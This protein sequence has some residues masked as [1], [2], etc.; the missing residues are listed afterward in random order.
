MAYPASPI[1][2]GFDV[3][4]LNSLARATSKTFERLA[5]YSLLQNT[6]SH[7]ARPAVIKIVNKVKAYIEA[8]DTSIQVVH[9]VYRMS[10]VAAALWSTP[11]P[12]SDKQGL[13]ERQQRL[14]DIV[15]LADEAH[16][17]AQKTNGVFKQV[18]QDFYRIAASTKSLDSTIQIPADPALPKLLKK[19]LKDIGPDL[20]SNLSLLSHFT[21]HSSDLATWCSWIKSSIIAIDGTV[22]PPQNGSLF[23][24]DNVRSRWERVRADCLIY[25]SMISDI[26][27]RYS[28]MLPISTNMWQATVSDLNTAHARWTENTGGKVKRGPGLSRKVSTLVQDAVRHLSCHMQGSLAG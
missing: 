20:V 8:I 3:L 28:A 23:E 6:S 13:R 9:I 17:K 25:H 2:Q 5:P 16:Q 18:Q 12:S 26:Q 21:R 19:S 14:E 11:A 24:A 27:N 15:I 22:V 7:E 1:A 10:K 4:D